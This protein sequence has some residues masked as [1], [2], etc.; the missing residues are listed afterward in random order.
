MPPSLL[1]DRDATRMTREAF[2]AFLDRLAAIGASP[3][4][5]RAFAVT[6]YADAELERARI[7]VV[8]ALLGSLALPD[9]AT[10]L[11]D[12]LRALARGLRERPA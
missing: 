7:Q 6:H 4:E 5:Y 11:A 1:P 12:Q 3:A 8:R 2:A 9:Q 10:A